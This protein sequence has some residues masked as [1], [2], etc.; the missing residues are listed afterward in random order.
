MGGMR[1]I[2]LGDFGG[3]AGGVSEP[4]EPF[5]LGEAVRACGLKVDIGT[6]NV[7]ASSGRSTA[8][9]R[10]RDLR[11]SLSGE[12]FKGFAGFACNRDGGSATG[13]SRLSSKGLRLKLL[14]PGA[15]LDL[16]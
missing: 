3:T 4:S 10:F 9:A 14:V 6:T 13:S 7:E 12:G 8:E 15:L 1:S 11:S 5:S 16:S 2:V